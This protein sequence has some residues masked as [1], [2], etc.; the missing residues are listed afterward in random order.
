MKS[1]LFTL[2]GILS[3]AAS[4]RAQSPAE[5]VEQAVGMSLNKVPGQATIIKRCDV[6]AVVSIHIQ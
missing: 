1:L 5:A 2:V 3:I 4:A 6:P